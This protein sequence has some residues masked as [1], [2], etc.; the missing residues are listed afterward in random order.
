[1]RGHSTIGEDNMFKQFNNRRRK[2]LDNSS[3]SPK[4]AR[5]GQGAG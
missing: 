2:A 5:M 3:T 4:R 1:M